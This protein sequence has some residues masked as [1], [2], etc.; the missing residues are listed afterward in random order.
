MYLQKILKRFLIRSCLLVTRF[1]TGPF[2]TKMSSFQTPNPE[3]F[4]GNSI[5]NLFIFGQQQQM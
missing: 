4:T 2:L 3:L 1:E 5:W